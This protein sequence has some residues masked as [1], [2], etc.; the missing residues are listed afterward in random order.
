MK[1]SLFSHHF[2]MLPSL[3]NLVV[4]TRSWT[5]LQNV[6]YW[7]N[8]RIWKWHSEWGIQCKSKSQIRMLFNSGIICYFDVKT[9]SSSPA[10][11]SDMVDWRVFSVNACVTEYLRIFSLPKVITISFSY[12]D[13]L[14][15]RCKVINFRK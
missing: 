13:C 3:S 15:Y 12:L 5:A 9:C 4:L 8:K 7:A 10:V 6:Y 2:Q 11:S 14:K 1:T